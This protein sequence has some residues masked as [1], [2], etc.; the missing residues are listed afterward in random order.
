MSETKTKRIGAL[1]SCLRGAI[2]RSRMLKEK[3]AKMKKRLKLADFVEDQREKRNPA[4]NAAIPR[5]V[6]TKR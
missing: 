3:K 5:G 1:S 6:L 2:I 4:V